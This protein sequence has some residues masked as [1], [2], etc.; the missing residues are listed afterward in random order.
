[1]RVAPELV[2]AARRGDR[3][4]FEAI[5]RE[6][7]RPIY[8]LVWRIVGNAE[9]AADVTQEVYLRTWRS[10][11]GFRGDANLATWLFRVATNAAL[12]QIGRRGRAA[13]VLEPEP[14]GVGP[15]VDETDARLDAQEIER[16]LLGLPAAQRAAVVLKDIY[17]WSCEEIAMQMGT[18]EGAVKV[19]LFRAR[20]RLAGELA[21]AGVVVS[22][23]RKRRGTA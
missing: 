14:A 1:M 15:A 6:T 7:Y 2:E 17:G 19:R 20:E 8:T 22:I 3:D 11:R 21:R 4:A 9:D 10:L 5:V 13:E 23:N 16:A 12:S 18:T